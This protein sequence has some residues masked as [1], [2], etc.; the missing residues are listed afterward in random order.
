MLSAR[1]AR[2]ATKPDT[3]L[4]SQL[5]GS[6]C[7][8]GAPRMVPFSVVRDFY[9][10]PGPAHKGF[11][12]AISRFFSRPQTIH[13]SAEVI[14]LLARILHK[15]STGEPSYLQFRAWLATL[16]SLRHEG[17]GLAPD[18]PE[19]RL[20]RPTEAWGRHR[21]SAWAGARGRAAGRRELGA[22][23]SG[24]WPGRRTGLGRGEQASGGRAGQSSGGRGGAI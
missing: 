5:P 8:R 10:Y 23:W 15:K 2:P 16:R 14:P 21:R 18:P 1:A 4:K 7:A 9:A 22:G 3:R 13:S 17:Q 24:R 19:N 20:G 6:S 12:P 11:R